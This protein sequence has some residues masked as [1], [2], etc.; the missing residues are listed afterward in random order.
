[1][2]IVKEK[3]SIFWF[4]RDL[5]LSDN[6]ALH[7]AL[8]DSTSVLPIFIFDTEITQELEEND[9]RITFIYDTLFKLNATLNNHGSSIYC[10][11]GK[12]LDVLM[13]LI[14]DFNVVS[15]FANEDYEPYG[16]T[17]DINVKRVLSKMGINFLLFKDI[18]IFAKEEVVKMNLSPY[19]VYT[20]YKNKWLEL[21]DK[22]II[23]SYSINNWNRFIKIKFKYPSL[24][25]S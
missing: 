7:C 5:R 6:H 15:V 3:V 13:K 16:I 22:Q 21:Y 23:Q 24:S 8:K 19:T 2:K 14:N 9:S 4:R 18:V 1:M 11:Q 25:K 10:L 12:P 20:P 17:R